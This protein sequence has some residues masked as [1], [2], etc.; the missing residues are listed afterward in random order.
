[1]GKQRV[2]NLNQRT[3]WFELNDPWCPLFGKLPLKFLGE[4]DSTRLVWVCI[5]V[6]EEARELWG[7]PKGWSA[8]EFGCTAKKLS[9]PWPDSK[10]LPY[11]PSDW[12]AEARKIFKAH[13]PIYDEVMRQPIDGYMMWYHSP[14]N[15]SFDDNYEFIIKGARSNIGWWGVEK[16]IKDYA[17]IAM[18]S[19]T[20]ARYILEDLLLCKETETDSNIQAKCRDALALVRRAS[21]MERT[22]KVEAEKERQHRKSVKGG[23]CPKK[24]KGILL[25]IEWARAKSIQK[26]ARG[27]WNYF[28]KK[29][30]E[31]DEYKVYFYQDPTGAGEDLLCQNIDGVEKGSIKFETFK[32]YVYEKNNG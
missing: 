13:E 29:S 3:K 15:Y 5:K 25:A 17:I 7:I 6:I 4:Y 14:T 11:Y 18:F 10:D 2:D 12:L 8:L 26:S 30:F 9:K 27:L 24:K 32:K 23:S 28:K 19:L 22:D 31:K 21:E 16:S 20:E 1:M